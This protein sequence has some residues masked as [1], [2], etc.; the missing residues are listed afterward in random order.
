MK[1]KNNTIFENS[2]KKTLKATDKIET[3]LNM[4]VS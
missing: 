4:T 2:T 1:E 3:T